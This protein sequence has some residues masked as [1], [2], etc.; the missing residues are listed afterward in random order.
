MPVTRP[1][2]LPAIVRGLLVEMEPH[3]FELRWHLAV[4][5]PEPDPKG[6]RKVNEMIDSTPDGW[7]YLMADDC[8]PFPS[9][10]RRLWEVIDANP[11]AG[12]IVVG[13]DRPIGTSASATPVSHER[14][15][16]HASPSTVRP[17]YICGG[18]II[19]ERSFLGNHRYDHVNHLHDSDGWMVAELYAKQPGRFVFV[20][21]LLVRMNSL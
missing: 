12:A 11:D 3:L 6:S 21:E 10:F 17:G 19:Y 18:Q 4:Q 9:F 20:D 7:L 13:Q 14:E 15:W 8:V 1:E 16:L 2:N 5:G